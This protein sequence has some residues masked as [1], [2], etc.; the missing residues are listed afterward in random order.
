MRITLLAYGSR[1]DVQP[2]IPLAQGLE[3]SGHTVTF[4]AG[5]NFE[6]LAREHGLQNFVGTVDT[7]AIMRGPEGYAWVEESNPYRQ[8][9]YVKR[10]F[11]QNALEVGGLIAET[12]QNA[13]LILSS[14]LTL[15]MA[16]AVSEKTGVPVID[17]TLQ[18]YSPTRSGAASLNALI[19][20]S[21]TILN[22]WVGQMSEAMI[23]IVA[24]EKT[25]EFRRSLG[26]PE[27]SIASYNRATH[28]LPTLYGFSPQ[29]VPP[30]DD[31]RDN[32]HAT[33]YWFLDVPDW[34]PPDDLVRFLESGTQPIYVGFGSM[35]SR[36]PQKTYDLI[37][38]ALEQTGQRAIV[39]SGWGGQVNTQ[40]E[41]ICV[42]DHAP[43]DW[44]FE[45]VA[46]VVHHGGAGTTAA[47]LRAGKPTLVIPHLADQPYWGRRVHELGVGAAP[48]KRQ[49]L[50]V[51]ALTAGIRQISSDATMQQHAADLGAKIRAEDGVGT[52]V[53]LIEQLMRGNNITQINT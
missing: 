14:F 25:N 19:P 29:V 28:A 44:L 36:D 24:R 5:R 15:P 39:A 26:L 22:Q 33:G 49:K 43:H 45:R 1:G 41:A 2:C 40:S 8:L 38:A 7:E 34:Q 12:A 4:V 21:A 9:R 52:A 6:A 53:K 48:I 3:A 13:D 30:P 42:V 46:A 35:P 32:V 10:A 11:D 18:P 31:W 50:T 51:E 47:G 17:A 16:Q 37:A 23:W 20:R 27:H